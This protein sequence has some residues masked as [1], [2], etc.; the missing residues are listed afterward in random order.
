MSRSSRAAFP[1]KIGCDAR[2]NLVTPR[3][4]SDIMLHLLG[5]GA[6]PAGVLRLSRGR[7]PPSGVT[8][9]SGGPCA[10]GCPMRGTSHSAQCLCLVGPGNFSFSGRQG[11][12][13][14]APVLAVETPC[15]PRATTPSAKRTVTP[16]TPVL[17]SNPG[18]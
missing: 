17:C 3:P 18:T 11:E 1:L 9:P 2:P 14:V 16:P 15:R 7:G 4:S 10:S 8:L 5:S 6:G 12:D 13:G